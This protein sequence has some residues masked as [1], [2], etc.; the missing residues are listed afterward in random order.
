MKPKFL[1][2]ALCAALVFSLASAAIAADASLNQK[3]D[4]ET[5]A[6][7]AA[8]LLDVKSGKI[9]NNPIV[10]VSKGKI[11]DLGQDIVIP[12]GAKQIDLGDVTLMPGMIDAHTHLLQNL[13]FETS[14]RIRE[15]GSMVHTLSTM[16]EVKRALLG[17][18]M[19]R[20]DLMSGITTVRDL[21]N[22]G[23]NADVD[24]R[25]AINQSWIQ[26]PRMLVSTR[27]LAPIG[28]QFNKLTKA[29][30]SLI[31]KEYAVISGPEEARKAVRSA[32]FDG[33]DVIKVIVDAESRLLTLE[34][35]QMIVNEAHRVGIK[36]AAHAGTEPAGM[37]AA[38]AGVDSIEHG[39]GISDELLKLMAKKNIAMVPTDFPAWYYLGKSSEKEIGESDQQRLNM[40]KYVEKLAAERIARIKAAGVRI[41]FGS[42]SYYQAGNL[43]RGQSSLL[44]LRVYAMAGLSPAEVIR[45]TTI[46]AAE[47]LGWDK[48]IGSLEKSKIADIIA[49]PGNPLDNLLVLEQVKFVMKDG[50]VVKP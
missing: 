4:I 7:K 34:E 48:K 47:L 23:T 26:G 18:T 28:G 38:Q 30:H 37:L 35:L 5:T 49:V 16:S 43:T 40:F 11:T 10:L 1:R 27:A 8:R 22:S 50:V 13:S 9:V 3:S 41:V 45:T 29:T 46:H 6:V 39:Y 33:A 36:V 12:L 32:I 31:D 17:A 15:S 44:P 21:G 2:R 20:E 14:A 42:D 19:A 24:L 25:D